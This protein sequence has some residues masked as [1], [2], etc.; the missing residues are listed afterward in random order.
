MEPG[1]EKAVVETISLQ[2]KSALES[3]GELRRAVTNAE[4]AMV[5]LSSVRA[6]ATA[7]LIK[8]AIQRQTDFTDAHKL[9]FR[10]ELL[11]NAYQDW[12]AEIAVKEAALGR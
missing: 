10:G 5:E 7:D 12:G 6:K 9:R 11:L 1:S 4:V 3:G 2:L 8:S